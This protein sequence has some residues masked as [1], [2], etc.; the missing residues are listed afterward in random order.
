MPFEITS[1]KSLSGLN[2][3]PKLGLGAAV[4]LWTGGGET[5]SLLFL[6]SA[7]I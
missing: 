5:T 1:I 4:S 3:S 2:S 6:L 7:C